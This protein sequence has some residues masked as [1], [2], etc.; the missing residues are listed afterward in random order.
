MGDYFLDTQYDGAWSSVF[1][2]PDDNCQRMEEEGIEWLVEL[3]H[4]VQ[5]QQFFV[6]IRDELQVNYAYWQGGGG[7]IGR[8]WPH[9]PQKN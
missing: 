1:I 4:Q 7:Q 2:C 5:L 6:R 8:A 3:L 9:S